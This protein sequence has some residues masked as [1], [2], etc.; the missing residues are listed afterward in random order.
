MTLQRELYVPRE[1]VFEVWTQP[2]HLAGWYAP[3]GCRMAHVLVE[4][5]VGGRLELAWTDE[6]GAA[7][8]E[9]GEFLE[10]HPPAGFACRL[11]C[12]DAHGTLETRMR[13]TLTH[14]VDECCIGIEQSGV[15]ETA[16]ERLRDAWSARLDRL[17]A[18]F[19]AI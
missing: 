7:V 14:G 11:R 19:S 4:P 8:H 16:A 9:A 18:Y 3:A 17:E 10:M 6:T 2:E 12:T 5:Q 1:L 15:P 13:L